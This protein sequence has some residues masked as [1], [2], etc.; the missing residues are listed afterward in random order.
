MDN[1]EQTSL[2]MNRTVLTVGSIHDTSDEKEFW[3]S[4]TPQERLAALELM[5]QIIYGYEYT[6]PPGLQRILTVAERTSG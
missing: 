5:R 4:K 3:L 1:F 2:R 6:A